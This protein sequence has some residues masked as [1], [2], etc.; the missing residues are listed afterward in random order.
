MDDAKAEVDYQL[1]SGD[2]NV[3][4][5]LAYLVG[6][7]SSLAEWF[8]LIPKS[9]VEE[10]LQIVMKDSLSLSQNHFLYQ[11]PSNRRHNS[12]QQ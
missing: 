11:H 3:E 5:I 4:E 2:V 1:K 12:D 10:A 8:D 6:A 7:Q 9:D